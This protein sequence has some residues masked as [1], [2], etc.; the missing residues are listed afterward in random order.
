MKS[1]LFLLLIS[2]IILSCNPKENIGYRNYLKAI[3]NQSTVQNFV[4]IKV[5]NLNTKETKEICTKGNFLLGAIHSEL[6][7]PYDSAGRKKVQVFAASKTDRYFEFKNP[8]ALK[9]VSFFSYK[10]KSSDHPDI[11]AKIQLIEK[12]LETEKVYSI[13]LNDKEMISIAHKLFKKGYLTAENSC[14]GGSL[15]CY[16]QTN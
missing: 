11:N 14:S 2:F 5:K 9:N 10:E 6:N 16:Q 1:Q 8:E 4:V 3:N 7:K 13:S 12:K 15:I